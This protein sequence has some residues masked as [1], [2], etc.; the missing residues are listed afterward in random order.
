MLADLGRAFDGV[1]IDELRLQ[2]AA[3]V[4]LPVARDRPDAFRLLWRHAWH[5]P[6]FGDLAMTFRRYVTY[7]AGEILGNFI[8]DD[9]VAP[10]LGR[11]ERRRPPPRVDLP[12][13]RRR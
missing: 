6:D 2:G 5:E 9:P 8:H 1:D 7:F 13:A 3:K 11:P 12:L 10:G 4:L